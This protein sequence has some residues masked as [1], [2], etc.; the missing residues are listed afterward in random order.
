V[1]AA[2]AVVVS[3][4][5]HIAPDNLFFRWVYVAFGARGAFASAFL[6]AS[7]A[8]GNF[9]FLAMEAQLRVVL[10]L[11][12]GHVKRLAVEMKSVVAENT[13]SEQAVEG[14]RRREENGDLRRWKLVDTTCCTAR[15]FLGTRRLEIMQ[16][17]DMAL[18]I[19][20]SLQDI[21]VLNQLLAVSMGHGLAARELAHQC[22]SLR[23]RLVAHVTQLFVRK[24]RRAFFRRPDLYN[25]IFA[26]FV[27]FF[28]DLIDQV[29]RRGRGD[30]RKLPR[31]W[32]RL[33]WSTV[34]H[35]VVTVF[36]ATSLRYNS[37]AVLTD[38][39]RIYV[40]DDET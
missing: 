12:T 15:Y 7:L 3:K 18:D 21:P 9:L 39:I 31:A 27:V 38:R 32:N 4:E 13:A 29:H 22:K 28:F 37:C 1:S 30:H 17:A 40:R 25:L 14:F 24:T 10:T 20:F 16:L 8:Y 34:V 35:S 2:A 26:V 5:A 33:V 23:V 19:V 11:D 6:E 36:T